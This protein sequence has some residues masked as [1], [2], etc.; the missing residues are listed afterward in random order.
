MSGDFIRMESITKKF[1][2]LSANDEVTLSVTEGEVHAVLG[3]NGAG[4]STLMNILT[5]IYA[6]DAGTIHLRGKEQRF[7]SPQDSIAAGIGMIY[8]HFKLIDALSSWENICAGTKG[9]PF[10]NPGEI[11]QKIRKL[12]DETG[13]YVDLDRKVRDMGVGEKQTVEILK[14]LYRG[15]E[16][17]ILDEPTTVLTPQETEV[18]FCIIRK[19]KQQGK[20]TVI[21]TH[22]LNEVM[23]ISDRVSVLRKG[24]LVATVN[25]ADVSQKELA[26]LMVG[27]AMNMEYPRVDTSP[28]RVVLEVEHLSLEDK[29]ASREL[30]DISFTLHASEIMGVAGVS[31]SGQKQLCHA[32]MGLQKFRQGTVRVCGIDI[33][34]RSSRQIMGDPE[35]SIAYIPEDR[36]GMG[37]ATGMDLVDNIMLRRYRSREGFLFDR[38]Y[39]KVKAESLSQSLSIMH[40]G[41]DRPIRVL[42]GGNMQKVLLGREIDTHPDVLIAAYPVRGLDLGVTHTVIDMLNEQK[43]AGAG[44][45]LVAEDLDLLLEVCDRILVLYCGEVSGIL[46]AADTGKEELGLLM[47]KLGENSQCSD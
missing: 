43:A 9:S 39:G 24:R 5:G 1:G 42:S 25:T 21:I 47:S 10:L 40:P 7:R 12:S 3:E 33:S 15:A 44:V 17:L 41:I 23:E 34:G 19:M 29:E 27:K 4:K 46:S 6:P 18:L 13:L 20:T 8:Q 26:E 30:K 14:V 32:L 36:T 16:V 35:V 2:S 31:G 28:G 11:K 37:L 22:K 45:L 38:E